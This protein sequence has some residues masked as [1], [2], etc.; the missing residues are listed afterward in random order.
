MAT[1]D[2][3]ILEEEHMEEVESDEDMEEKLDRVEAK[4][5]ALKG[6]V[7]QTVAGQEKRLREVERKVEQLEAE[8]TDLKGSENSLN[9]SLSSLREEVDL[10]K[11]DGMSEESPAKRRKDERCPESLD[12]MQ[13]DQLRAELRPHY[14]EDVPQSEKLNAVQLAF[15]H[16]F[17]G[18][19]ERGQYSGRQS[20]GLYLLHP[21]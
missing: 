3:E 17:F 18:T 16:Y 19:K 12:E 15:L 6:V 2:I 11:V 21:S 9:E 13:D 14:L 4:F 10:L 7:L 8:M 1:S 20:L 5:D